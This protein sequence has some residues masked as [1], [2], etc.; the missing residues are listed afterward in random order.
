[1][2]QQRVLDFLYVCTHC[3]VE[4]LMSEVLISLKGRGES[5][6]IYGHV[7]IAQVHRC[8]EPMTSYCPDLIALCVCVCAL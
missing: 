4:S 3:R 6:P 8:P 1:M 7:I 2:L 5:E